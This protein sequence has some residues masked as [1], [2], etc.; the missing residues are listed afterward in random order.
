[1]FLFHTKEIWQHKLI[2]DSLEEWR[3]QV[4]E[5]KNSRCW[6]TSRENKQYQVWEHGGLNLSAQATAQ[7]VVPHGGY[8]HTTLKLGMDCGN[9]GFKAI[10]WQEGRQ[11]K[12]DW[13]AECLT[14]L[15]SPTEGGRLARRR[16]LG[17][18]AR[19][20]GCPDDRLAVYWYLLVLLV[21]SQLP[22]IWKLLYSFWLVSLAESCNW[23]RSSCFPVMILS[24]IRSCY[25]ECTAS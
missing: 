17:R 13:E 15:L 5:Y 20:S 4:L 19:Y 7:K 1:M 25:S 3:G 16:I 23:K 12:A 9:P 10:S 24:H 21:F 2:A 6:N 8:H 11:A 22:R 18:L 14:V